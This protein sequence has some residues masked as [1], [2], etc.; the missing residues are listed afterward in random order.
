MVDFRRILL[1]LL[2]VNGDQP[3]LM[4]KQPVFSSTPESLRAEFAPVVEACE[5]QRM[6]KRNARCERPHPT[7]G[8]ERISEDWLR[9]LS[10]REC[11][12]QFRY[13]FSNLYISIG[14]LTGLYSALRVTASELLDMVETLKIPPLITTRNQ[15]I[16]DSI[17]ALAL[18]LARFRSA[19]DQYDLSMRFNRSQSSISEI[20]N[21]V[22]THVDERWQHL[23]EFD[24]KHLLSPANL[25][26]YTQ[27]I[28]RT[29]APLTRVWGFIDCTIRRICR[30]SM[31]Q[32][33]AY[34]GHKKFHALKFQAMMLPNGMCMLW[35]G[36]KT[37]CCLS[38]MG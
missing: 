14:K 12:S 30:P 32:R 11:L 16:F 7:Q 36:R 17:E 21:W 24:Y 29:G 10:D 6:Q 1:G 27:A 35:N 23:L 15:Y 34:S 20:V 3:P 8:G 18:T 19:S 9:G 31:W 2:P 37:V 5:R 28:H 22:V 26:T 25:E 38:M 33:A 13:L 4:Q